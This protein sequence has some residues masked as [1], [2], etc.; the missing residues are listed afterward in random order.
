MRWLSPIASCNGFIVFYS[1]IAIG[2]LALAALGWLARGWWGRRSHTKRA[3][4]ARATLPAEREQLE[5]KFLQAANATGKPRGL[6]WVECNFQEGALFAYDRTNGDI[7]A[8]RGVTIRFE[9]IEG[10]GMEEVEA[11]G[12]LRYATAVFN[13]RKNIWTTDGRAVFNL[14]PQETLEKYRGSLVGIVG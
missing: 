1:L 11:V 3:D 9:A 10:G 4:R 6:R 12:N 2:L 13:Y 7:C 14:S 5:R 8:L